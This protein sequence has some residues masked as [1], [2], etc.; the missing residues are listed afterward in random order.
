MQVLTYKRRISL[1]YRDIEVGGKSDKQYDIQLVHISE[2]GH[3]VNFQYGR[4]GGTMQTGTKTPEPVSFDEAGAIFDR[5][6][7]EKAAKGYSAAAEYAAAGPTVLQP[8]LPAIQDKLRTRCPVELLEEIQLDQV[9][10]FVASTDYWMQVKVDGHRRQIEKLEPGNYASYNKKGRLVTTLPAEV[11]HDLERIAAKSF[12]VDG[13][14]IGNSYVAYD[15]FAVDGKSLI[16]LPYAKRMEALD[17]LFAPRGANSVCIT[18]V[19][20]WRTVK[21][22][23]NGMDI[24][25]ANRCEGVVFK[26]VNAP[27]RSGESGQ[28]MKFKFVK[29]ASCKVTEVGH[30]GKDNAVL[31]LL[32]RAGKW[33][34]V[35]H[36]STIGKGKIAVGDIVEVMFLYVTEGHRL[37]QPR[38]K[39]V[40]DDVV[41]RDCSIARQ[42]KGKYKEGVK[43]AA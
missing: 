23:I 13:E 6:I 28:H 40:R 41:D 21:E 9:K 32:D 8:Q 27:Y 14:L 38:I 12:L 11:V 17:K 20:T 29:S 16:E 15:C 5:L 4:R 37:Y 43:E 3:L 19:V 7:Q 42:L 33:V 39:E 24:A 34:E 31:A 35:A 18:R 25:M 22:K 2:R 26:R 30:K 10:R 36:V 1:F